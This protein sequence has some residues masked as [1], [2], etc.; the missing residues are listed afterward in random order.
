MAADPHVYD[1]EQEALLFRDDVDEV[2][3]PSEESRAYLILQ[4]WGASANL[5]PMK[6]E[7]CETGYCVHGCSIATARRLV[8]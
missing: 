1:D 2:F 4:W 5:D 6:P 3:W 8:L 7:P